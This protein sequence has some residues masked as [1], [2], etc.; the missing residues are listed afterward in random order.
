MKKISTLLFMSI[1][2]LLL[3]MLSGCNEKKFLDVLPRGT[4]IAKTANDFRALLDAAD[5]EKFQYSLTQTGGM[6][7]ILSDDVSLDSASWNLWQNQLGHFRGLFTFENVVWDNDQLEEDRNWKIP[8]YINSTTT[9]VLEEIEKVTDNIA[10]KNQLIAEAKVHRAYA[11]LTLVNTYAKA[12]NP[13]TASTDPGVPIITKPAELPPLIRN[14]VGEV[15]EYILN[16]LLSAIES[17]PEN[18]DNYKHRPTKVSAY[19]ILA[20]TYLYMG[21]FENARLYS[22]KSLQIHNFLYDFNTEFTGAYPYY[23][24]FNGLSH[25]TD[26]EIILHKT[27]IK[28][29]RTYQYMII[30]PGSFNEIYPGYTLNGTTYT[31]N[32][33]RRTL[34]FYGWNA[35][36]NSLSFPY[37]KY[38][39]NFP[40]YRYKVDGNLSDAAYN[41][42]ITT[43]EMFVTRA[44]AN[45]RLGNLQAA[46]DDINT[47]AEKRHKT[48]TYV[49]LTLAGLGNNQ[50]NVIEESL[51]ERRR[52]LYGKDLRLF[53]I[54]RLHMPVIHYLGSMKI[55]VP[56]DDPRLVLP[57]LPGY[58][59][60][61]QE[62]LQNDRS[63]SGVTYN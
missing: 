54:K 8:Y 53:D 21:D 2:Y 45:A 47:L 55:S 63:I 59:E 36:V 13:A 50:E 4:V 32:D 15:Y 25:N 12:Y 58:I 42:P 40:T 17:L 14:S 33:L 1:S 23:N 60:R 49:Q 38:Y 20:R 11:Y 48:G 19:A 24:K 37:L 39:G 52:E 43:G 44:E 16:D 46:L 31:N 26:Q 7:D 5:N 51:N 35:S 6:A 30:D 3:L 27:S 56:A 22:D 18:A 57:I 29:L 61:N 10:L 9:I 34:W 41:Q 28:G 62:L